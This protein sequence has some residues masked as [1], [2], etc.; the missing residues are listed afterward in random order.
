VTFK[1]KYG[2]GVGKGGLVLVGGAKRA[3]QMKKG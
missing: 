2:I 3:L 1:F